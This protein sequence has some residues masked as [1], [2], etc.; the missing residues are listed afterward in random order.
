LPRFALQARPLLKA[1]MEF[2][3]GGT[4]AGLFVG[5]GAGFGFITPLQLHSIPVMGQLASSISSSLGSIDALLGGLGSGARR[6]TRTLGVKGLDVGFGCGAMIG[7]G[8]GAGLML[9]PDALQAVATAAGRVKE[10]VLQRLPPELVKAS[11]SAGQ[12]LGA[13]A[14]GTAVQPGFQGTLAPQ[15]VAT[16]SMA[17]PTSGREAFP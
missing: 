14:A 2:R 12:P 5:C 13:A 6:H 8:Y 16:R 9:T 4:G 1:G 11:G 10:Q 17:A 3:V 15:S 7:Y